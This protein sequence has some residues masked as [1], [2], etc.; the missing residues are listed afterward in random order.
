MNKL[1][2][3]IINLLIKAVVRIFFFLLFAYIFGIYKMA[4]PLKGVFLVGLVG[5]L[6]GAVSFYLYYKIW[7]YSR[8]IDI[9]KL[10]IGFI[11]QMAKKP[12]LNP[13]K[14]VQ[15]Q[16]IKYFFFI[17]L[18][19][20]AIIGTINIFNSSSNDAYVSEAA[21]YEDEWV[22]LYEKVAVLDFEAINLN[23]GDVKTFTKK[24]VSEMKNLDEF[25]LL[26]EK[27]IMSSLK[28]SKYQGEICNDIECA[29]EIGKILG[30][31]Y[32]IIGSISK[33]DNDYF[34]DAQFVPVGMGKAYL[35]AIYTHSGEAYI[36]IENGVPSIAKQLFGMFAPIS[37]KKIRFNYFQHHPNGKIELK[38][39]SFVNGI[40]NGYWIGYDEKGKITSETYFK[41]DDY[42]GLH[43]LLYK[44]NKED[45][46]EITKTTYLGSRDRRIEVFRYSVPISKTFPCGSSFP[47]EY[48]FWEPGKKTIRK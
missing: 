7:I 32:I 47:K 41:D 36:L 40:Q 4:S 26:D 21:P 5:A 3:N 31:T 16:Y 46:N 14:L 17:I 37:S 24:L 11:S 8:Q 2:I 6:I 33:F 9:T 38:G 20:L 35:K 18:A 45:E 34:I 28:G 1:I 27:E 44:Y 30:V 48:G 42:Y 22:T 23:S 43:Y 10:N 15:S 39:E 25:P 29:V 19:L 13:M 12:N